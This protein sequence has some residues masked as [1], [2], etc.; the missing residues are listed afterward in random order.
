MSPSL[1]RGRLVGIFR[2]PLLK[3]PPDYKLVC[4]YLAH[5]AT[6]CVTHMLIYIAGYAYAYASY[7]QFLKKVVRDNRS[8][9]LSF[10][11]FRGALE[12]ETRARLCDSRQK[13]RL[14]AREPTAPRFGAWWR[15]HRGRAVRAMQR[16]PDHPEG[17][18]IYKYMYIYIYIYICF[19]LSLY[20]Y[21][22]TYQW[23]LDPEQVLTFSQL[24][25]P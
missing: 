19:S 4:T 11:P 23:F 1:R 9:L 22:Y 15:I 21:I 24:R 10:D 16:G 18:H 6:L 3:G 2:G 14:R 20:I 13:N 5:S 8:R 25:Y 12:V 7:S 17:K